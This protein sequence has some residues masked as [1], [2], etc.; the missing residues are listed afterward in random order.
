MIRYF[1][2]C[3]VTLIAGCSEAVYPKYAALAESSCARNDGWAKLSASCGMGNC[4]FDITCKDGALFHAHLPI[5]D[6]QP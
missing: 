6:V 2:V 4:A 1:L 5:K 3:A